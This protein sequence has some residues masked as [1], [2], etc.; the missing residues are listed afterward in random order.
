MP[1]QLFQKDTVYF[2]HVPDLLYPHLQPLPPIQL[3]YTIRVDKP[4]INGTPATDSDPALPPSAPTVYDI[5]VPLPN[6]V[7]AQLTKFHT[8]RA[9]IGD[10]QT[11][12][13][14][15]DELA[16]L[17][18]KVHQTNA[19]RKFYENLAKDPASFVKRWFS[20]QMRDQDVILAESTR[21]GGEDAP[22]ELYRRG[23]KDGL[24]DSQQA[25]E[26]VGLWLARNTKS[27]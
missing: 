27:H 20:S 15:D 24:W 25:H 3:A 17:V 9:H 21:G 10:L 23:G 1:W 6:P 14:T 13:R 5:R 4:Y 26:S 7:I 19:K 18:Q 12:V 16:L 11:I 8:S 2:P 22:G